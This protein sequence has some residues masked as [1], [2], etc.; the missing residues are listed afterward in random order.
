LKVSRS[1]GRVAQGERREERGEARF[2]RFALLNGNRKAG[3]KERERE[4]CAGKG[5]P[6]YQKKGRSF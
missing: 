6:L 5:D 3:G 1:R 2:V 4:G